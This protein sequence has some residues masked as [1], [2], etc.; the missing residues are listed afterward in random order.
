MR[1]DGN[2][3]ADASELVRGGATDSTD[4]DEGY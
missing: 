3:M 1:N 2:F 4:T